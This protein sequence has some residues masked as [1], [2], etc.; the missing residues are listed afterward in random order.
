VR[1]A[2]KFGRRNTHFTAY[3][4]ALRAQ[5]GRQDAAR[6]Y[7]EREAFI[8]EDSLAVMADRAYAEGYRQERDRIKGE[9]S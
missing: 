1:L 8:N 6:D 2:G 4:E 3:P 5:W 9:T 7:A